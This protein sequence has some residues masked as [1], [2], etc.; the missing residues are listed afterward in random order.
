MGLPEWMLTVDSR[1]TKTLH[2]G[3]CI[4]FYLHFKGALANQIEQDFTKLL[5][6]GKLDDPSVYMPGFIDTKRKKT[7][8]YRQCGVRDPTES[9]IFIY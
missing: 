3:S 1:K 2:H 4:Q 5:T 7:I 8:S 6:T 9:E